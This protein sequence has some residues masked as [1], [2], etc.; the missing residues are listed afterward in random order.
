MRLT[1]KILFGE[2][3]ITLKS[4]AS[5]SVILLFL[6]EDAESHWKQEY[7]LGTGLAVFI[8]GWPR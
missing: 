8:E 6:L 5:R 3:E 2:K 4:T 1:T 7:F